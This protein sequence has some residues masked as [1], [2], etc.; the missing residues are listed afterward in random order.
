MF[1][2]FAISI[3]DQLQGI[4]IYYNNVGYSPFT[5][6]SINKFIGPINTLAANVFISS[7]IESL[8]LTVRLLSSIYSIMRCSRE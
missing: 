1:Q 6:D 2:I 5:K 3:Y 4:S 7:V 8:M